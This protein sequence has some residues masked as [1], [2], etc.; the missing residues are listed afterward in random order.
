MDWLDRVTEY[1]EKTNPLAVRDSDVP[2]M[3]D[4]PEP[5]ARHNITVIGCIRGIDGWY[6][7]GYDEQTKTI[8]PLELLE[9]IEVRA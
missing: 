3:Q 4:P 7:C 8:V 9:K 1:Q 2:D 6:R 5:R